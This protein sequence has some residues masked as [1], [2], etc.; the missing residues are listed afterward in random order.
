MNQK[1]G[2]AQD[3]SMAAPKALTQTAIIHALIKH[4][5]DTGHTSKAEIYEAVALA[6]GYPRPTI[7]R[8]AS[9]LSKE[10]GK[11]IDIQNKRLARLSQT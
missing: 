6:T 1:A 11:R 3:A 8:A 10:I 4:M 2:A 7:R 5:I 9:S